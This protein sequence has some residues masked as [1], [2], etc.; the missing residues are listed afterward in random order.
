MFRTLLIASLM[1]GSAQTGLQAIASEA[2]EIDI[3]PGLWNWSFT[4]KLA[5]Q[6]FGDRSSGCIS[7]SD[8]RIPLQSIADKL[9]QN[10]RLT[11]VVKQDDG[12]VF[13]LKCSGFYTGEAD[14]SLTNQSEDNIIM[15]AIGF[16][17]FDGAKAEFEF[18]AE[19]NHIGTCQ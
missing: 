14:V 18:D 19:A 6:P 10:C 1:V 7:E 11:N 17:D 3:K 9:G 5:K 16:V 2:A 12:Y 4:A 15:S 8:S 13:G